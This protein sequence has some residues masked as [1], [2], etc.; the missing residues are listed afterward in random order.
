MIVKI[1]MEIEDARKLEVAMEAARK[2]NLW[3]DKVHAI[4]VGLSALRDT[5]A[6]KETK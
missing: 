4:D 5:I 1:E 3:S 6:K 2:C